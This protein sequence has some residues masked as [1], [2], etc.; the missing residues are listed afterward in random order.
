[1]TIDATNPL[2]VP[3]ATPFA[4]PPFA[5][6]RPTHIRP[7]FAAALRQHQAD[8]AAI[9]QNAEPP[10]FANTLVELEKIVRVHAP[11]PAELDNARA[12]P[13]TQEWTERASRIKS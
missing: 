4:V 13:I 1:M 5:Q 8:V 11:N 7:A 6:I 9:A 2:L 12:G 3:A 10:T